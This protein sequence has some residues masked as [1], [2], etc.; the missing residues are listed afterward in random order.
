MAAFERRE[1]GRGGG[2]GGGRVVIVMLGR[3]RMTTDP[4]IPTMPRRMTSSFHL[5]GIRCPHQVRGAARCC[6]RRM[7]GELN[8]TKNRFRGAGGESAY[9]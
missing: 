7:K 6:A 2:E 5:P 4:R 8:P 1:D 9:G 3:S